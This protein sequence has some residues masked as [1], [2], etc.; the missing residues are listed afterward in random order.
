MTPKNA[1][2]VVIIAEALI[3]EQIIHLIKTLGINGYILHHGITGHGDKGIW[4]GFDGGGIFG[5]NFRIE[6]LVFDEAHANLIMN[7][8]CSHFFK[9]YSGIVY[10]TDIK[11]VCNDLIPGNS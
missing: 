9:H 3:E 11:I 10:T 5:D 7:E 8:V 1:K 2:L 6:T 4:S